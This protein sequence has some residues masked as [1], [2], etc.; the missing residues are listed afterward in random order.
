MVSRAKETRSENLHSY[1]NFPHFPNFLHGDN[2]DGVPSTGGA[3]GDRCHCR[4]LLV[5]LDWPEIF[6]LIELGWWSH[7]EIRFFGFRLV[8]EI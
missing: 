4:A 2:D 6:P 3:A 7:M 8:D 5:F 1:M